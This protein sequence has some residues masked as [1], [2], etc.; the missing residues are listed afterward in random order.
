MSY[1]APPGQ[2]NSSNGIV[3]GSNRVGCPSACRLFTGCPVQNIASNVSGRNNIYPIDNIQSY[4]C[5]INSGAPIP[6]TQRPEDYSQYSYLISAPVNGVGWDDGEIVESVSLD[7]P[8]TNPRSSYMYNAFYSLPDCQADNPITGPPQLPHG[9]PRPPTR[10][11]LHC[12]NLQQSL[13]WFRLK[14]K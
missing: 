6:H 12:T 11:P 1:F 7:E 14:N 3:Q 10:Q 2:A 4:Y 5:I 13:T 9:A 8:Y